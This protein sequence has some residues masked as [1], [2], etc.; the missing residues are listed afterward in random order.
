MEYLT[1]KNITKSFTTRHLLHEVSFSVRKGHKVALVA[2]NGMGKSTLLKIIMGQIEPSEGD[3]TFAKNIRIG[4]LS[5]TFPVD[6]KMSVLD[7]LFTHDHATGQLIRRYEKILLDPHADDTELHDILAQ[8][9]ETHAWEYETQVKTVISKLHLTDLLQQPM[10]SLSGGE[11][12]RVALAK[13]LLDEPD[14]LILDEPTNHLDLD[15]IERLERYLA[16]SH[17][18]LLMVTHDRYFLDSVC[19][20][21]IE[22]ERGV[23]H[24]YVGNYENFI[25]KKAE[26]E[27]LEQRALHHL[28]QL[29]KK[30][31]AWVRK[32]PRGRGTKS[33]SREKKFDDIDETFQDKK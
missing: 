2:Q 26:R 12:K 1:V 23:L 5:Q 31:L 29:W 6:P 24:T 14:F 18:T 33:V 27:A 25:T 7:A 17:L 15:M 3:I 10:G 16:Q 11:A 30:E 8:I 13:V 22:L 32:A 21:I 4:F 9:E 20:T 28:K 19:D